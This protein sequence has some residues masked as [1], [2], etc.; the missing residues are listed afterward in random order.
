MRFSILLS[1]LL[2]L[3]FV[4]VAS[5]PQVMASRVDV[6]WIEGGLASEVVVTGWAAGVF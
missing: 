6:T 5:T 1:A 2:L 4:A 3:C